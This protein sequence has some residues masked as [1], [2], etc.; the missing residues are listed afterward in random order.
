MSVVY[1]LMLFLIFYEQHLFCMHVL[2]SLWFDLLPQEYSSSVFAFRHIYMM[3]MIMHVLG[4]SKVKKKK[5]RVVLK[6]ESLTENPI[7][8]VLCFDKKKKR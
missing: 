2:D 7:S 3:Y 4:K 5:G 8:C 1:L 6:L